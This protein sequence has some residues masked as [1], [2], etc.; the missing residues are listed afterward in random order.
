[1][2]IKLHPTQNSFFSI[3]HKE[4]KNT[5]D[6]NKTLRTSLLADSLTTLNFR[7]EERRGRVN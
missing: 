4:N 3:N 1:M 6:I 7:S 2:L 5:E